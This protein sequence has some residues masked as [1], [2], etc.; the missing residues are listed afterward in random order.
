MVDCLSLCENFF[1]GHKIIAGPSIDWGEFLTGLYWCRGG[2]SNSHEV[3]FGG[4]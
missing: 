3:A 2:D 4:F 1:L